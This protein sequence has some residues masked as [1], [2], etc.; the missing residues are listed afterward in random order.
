MDRRLQPGRG[1]AHGADR[2]GWLAGREPPD[3]AGRAVAAIR[4]A[5][6]ESGRRIDDDHYGAGF[7]YRFGS[8]D[9]PFIAERLKLLGQSFPDRDPRDAMV[10]G[11]A[12]DIVAR[13]DAYVRNG[14]SKF[15]LR[16]SAP[17]TTRS[18]TRRAV[19]STR[20]SPPLAR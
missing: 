7:Y 16:P 6:A 12:A 20:S 8:P 4:A 15:I 17:P 2:T 19:S 5:C 3:E 14:V 18:S 11:G 1:P 13:L 9:E 10:V